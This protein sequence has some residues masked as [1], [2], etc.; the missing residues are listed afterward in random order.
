VAG[1]VGAGAALLRAPV[2]APAAAPSADR[3]A[4]RTDLQGDPLPPGALARLGTIRFR[5]P[6]YAALG[7]AFSSDGKTLLSVRHD[8]LRVW[9][10]GSGR[11]LRAVPVAGLHFRCVAF[12]PDRQL[13]AVGGFT[14]AREDAPAVGTIRVLDTRTGKV[15]RS[16]SR[17]AERM[18]HVA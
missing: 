3:P 4:A 12:S 5:H 10:A 9:D 1:L 15:V 8:G 7:L 14:I 2:G 18:D 11:P 13:L 16:W 17:G 6:G